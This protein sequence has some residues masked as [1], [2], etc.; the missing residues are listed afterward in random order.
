MTVYRI[1]LLMKT[2]G[3]IRAKEFFS[4]ESVS[5]AVTPI[6]GSLLMLIVLVVLAS[7]TAIS[8]SNIANEGKSTQPL[9]ARISLESCE[10]G[11]SSTNFSEINDEETA[12][13]QKNRIVLLHKGGDSLPLDT[14]SIKI[15][16]DGNAY[17]G[18]V[19]GGGHLLYGD[20]QVIYE[21]LGSKEKNNT[22][23]NQNDALLKDGFW[24]VG[25][26]LTLHGRDRWK[27][28]ISTVKVSVNGDSD[29]S[30][31]YGFKAGSEITL[32]VIDI[33]SSNVIAEQK[34]IVKHAV[35]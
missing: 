26:R 35:S 1:S 10:G 33:K 32:K 22:Y 34:V 29:T 5:D 7:V 17:Q 19:T 16:G 6:I 8:F 23:A 2:W 9:M 27:S 20:T 3:K 31:N 21:N 15:S 13:F 24:S 11:L 12:N 30:N 4:S 14:I 28:D 18:I 25:E